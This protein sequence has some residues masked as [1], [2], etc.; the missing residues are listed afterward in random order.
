MSFVL[1]TILKKK[2][3]QEK[4]SIESWILYAKFI[5]RDGPQM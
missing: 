3:K 2:Q 4:E 5:P 1:I